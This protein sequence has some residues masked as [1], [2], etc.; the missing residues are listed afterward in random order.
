MIKIGI[1]GFGR[2][3]RLVLRA[4]LERSTSNVEVVALNDPFMDMDYLIYLLKYDSAHG[5]FKGQIEKVDDKTLKVNGKVIKFFTEKDPANIKWGECGA[6]IVC[7]STGVFI[8]TDKAKAHI[9]GGAKVVIISA[10]AKDDT[11]TFVYGVNHE[12]Y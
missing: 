3:G 8:T 7:E 2:I 11:P 12:Q 10:P 1:N 6:E 4:T 9:A 5:V